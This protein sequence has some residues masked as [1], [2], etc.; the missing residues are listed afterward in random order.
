M[1][2]LTFTK[3][4][5]E[6]MNFL[7]EQTEPLAVDQI[8]ARSADKNWSEAYIRVMVR[9]LE[10]KGLLEC[11]GVEPRGKQYARC[12][13][14]AITREEHYTRM[15]LTA[16]ADAG[17]LAKVA[18]ASVAKDHKEDPDEL[19]KQL[20]AIVDDFKAHNDKAKEDK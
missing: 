6:L 4:E 9:S 1:R 10:H 20:E 3:R 17:F 2:K 7:W 15:A 18:V 14:P 13:R 16:G 8:A 19:I 12:F 5:E 11:C